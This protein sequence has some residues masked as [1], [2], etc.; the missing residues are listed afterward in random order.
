M[1]KML[2]LI[3]AVLTV[4]CVVPS[5]SVYAASDGNDLTIDA[6]N[7]T[8][9]NYQID[10]YLGRDQEKRSTLTTVENIQVQ[11]PDFDQ[12]HGIER[13]IPNQYNGHKTHLK[14]KSVK[15]YG[16]S[17]LPYQTRDEGDMTIVRIGDP[18]AYVHGKQTY[19]ITYEQHDVTTYI[20]NEKVDEFYWDT[21]GTEWRIPIE[22]L[23]VR[24]HLANGLKA[25]LTGKQACY[26]G[27][28]G[29]TDV[30][31]IKPTDYGF[32]ATPGGPLSNYENMTI[33]VG[34]KAGT[35]GA[36]KATFWEKL[37]AIWLILL[38]ITFIVAV[39]IGTWLIYRYSRLSGRKG[40]VGTIIPEYT[41][42]KDVSV[43]TAASI[44][45]EP[46]TVI[47]AQMLDFAVRGFVKI[48]ETR[49]KSMFRSAQYEVEI[50]QDIST[51]K[52][53]ERE[54]LN[55]MFDKPSV[56]SRLK[57]QEL[58]SSSF[59][60][61]I[62]DNS[63]KLDK[64]IA[65]KYGL[66]APVP[67][68]S[69]SF[70]RWALIIL[71]LAIVTVSPWL[72]LAAIISFAFGMSLKP[73]TDNGLQLYRYLKGL[74]MYISVAETDRI[75]MLQSPEGA[76]KIGMQLDPS[77]PRQLIKLYEKVLPYAVLFGKE[78]EWNK[79]IGQYYEAVNETPVWFAGSYAGF[80]AAAFSSAMSSFSTTTSYSSSTGG[81]S[82]GGFSGGGGGGGG[83]GAW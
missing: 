47:S 75:R 3:V 21:N 40:E 30:C 42:P 7:H 80:N 36:Y 24:L 28:S 44:V 8:I 61:N 14:I 5:L 23:D 4:L 60:S 50:T 25:T 10:Y 81:S 79:R 78:K 64:D 83:G 63:E 29:S 37:W 45:G 65:G 31:T 58:K 49:P 33:A 70:K 39:I 41:P 27:A 26:F 53:E 17:P 38:F 15:D 69:K 82:G 57:L 62:S 68:Q 77:N 46:T 74:E 73:L 66:R 2:T 52:D 18:D 1:K 34:F 71:I 6:Y 16:G 9:P 56:G 43:S 32:S 72:L 67:L 51:L 13:Y 48:Y 59:I 54:L 55:D 19:I 22:N 76:Q 35:F 11:F 12:N 20:A